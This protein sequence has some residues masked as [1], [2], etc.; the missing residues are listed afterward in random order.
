LRPAFAL[1]GRR[2]QRCRITHAENIAVKLEPEAEERKK[3]PWFE[4]SLV[5]IMAAPQHLL[6]QLDCRRRI[7]LL[8][9]VTGPPTIPPYVF[10]PRPRVGFVLLHR[11]P[12]ALWMAALLIWWVTAATTSTP[13]VS[14]KPRLDACARAPPWEKARAVGRRAAGAERRCSKS[15]GAKRPPHVPPPPNLQASLRPLSNKA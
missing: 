11:R 2:P 3:P 1:N 8:D 7:H 14:L 5:E 6:L 12:Q 10:A 13:R 9:P 15:A 4:L